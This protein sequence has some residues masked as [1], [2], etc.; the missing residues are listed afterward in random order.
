MAEDNLFQGLPPPSATPPSSNS[1]QQQPREST[2]GTN[3]DPSPIP[4]PAL[5]SALKRCN[6]PQPTSEKGILLIRFYLSFQKPFNLLCSPS[7][8]CSFGFLQNPEQR[9]EKIRNWFLIFLI[10]TQSSCKIYCCCFFFLFPFTLEFSRIQNRAL[11]NF[12]VS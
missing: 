11:G 2:A 3:K 9:E 6:P 5:K 7:V 10:S 8:L 1:Q 4:P 12:R